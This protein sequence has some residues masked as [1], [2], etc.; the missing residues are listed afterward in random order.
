MSVFSN[1]PCPRSL[2]NWH[3]RH[4]PLDTTH[5]PSLQIFRIISC[6]GKSL[7]CLF[8]YG[9]TSL[10][11]HKVGMLSPKKDQLK[12]L[13]PCNSKL[14]TK[15][16]YIG[17]RARTPCTF[18]DNCQFCQNCVFCVN[19][20]W[21]K[22]KWTLYDQYTLKGHELNL[23]CI[24]KLPAYELVRRAL[25]SRGILTFFLPLA[26]PKTAFIPSLLKGRLSNSTLT[27]TLFVDHNCSD[28]SHLILTLSLLVD[29]M[30]LEKCLR[31]FEPLA[32]HLVGNI[33]TKCSLKENRL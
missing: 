27:S 21:I 18:W 4:P 5:P 9:L 31:G 14:Y 2:Q 33:T 10:S 13:A 32:T 1:Q 12:P 16:N 20:L 15:S 11:G 17:V 30:G 24:K 7:S 23:Y 25:L 29:Q 3:W 6:K 8:F 28:L 22:W 26:P 19:K